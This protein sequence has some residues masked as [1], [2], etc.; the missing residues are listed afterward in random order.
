[1]SE[2]EIIATSSAGTASI[3]QHQKEITIKTPLVTENSLIYITP[4]GKETTQVPF[5]LRQIPK[6]SFTVGISQP[7]T[8]P[9]QF[10]WL[11]IN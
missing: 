4:V 10:N 1:M 6:E 9:T 2:K 8:I 7:A 5:L 11:I 3:A